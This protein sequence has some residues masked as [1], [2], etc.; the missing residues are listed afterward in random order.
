MLS[1]NLYLNIVLRVTAIILLALLLGYLVFM[2]KSVKL[3]LIC[4]A[5]IIA[6]TTELISFLNGVNSK[7]RF[8]FDSVRNDDS[9]INFNPGTTD[10]TLIEL[11]KSMMEVNKQISRLKLDNLRQEQYFRALI[12]HLAIGIITYDEKGMILH[13]NKA[14][15]KLLSMEVLTHIRQIGRKDQKLASAIDEIKPGENKLVSILNER[16]ETGLSLKATSV[17]IQSA[18]HIILS[19][20]DIG[21]ELEEKEIE[22]WLKLIRVLTHEIMNSITPITSLS[23]SLSKI[24]ITGNGRIGADQLTESKIET[25]IQGLNVIREQ[26]KGLLSF[27]ESYREMTRLPLP[28]KQLFS[29]S[30]LLDRVNMLYGSL[31][32]NDRARLFIELKNSKA[33]LYA[34]KNLISQ[35]LLNLLKNALE[36]IGDGIGGK[37]TINFV[38]GPDH[39]HE[40]SVSDNGPGIP[41]ENLDKVFVPFFT[42]RTRGTGIGLSISRQIM[43]S[44]GGILKV[45][46]V[47]GKETVFSLNF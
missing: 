18:R 16:G 1:R 47:P 22:S 26:G 8:F 7:I 42:T 11:Y 4:L 25:T 23:E 17:N 9:G 14:A 28:E 37:I 31:E 2:L 24:Y 6:V 38:E 36:S 29:V 13:A 46:S 39:H 5:V 33:E 43:K 41:E 35:V 15:L 3:S 40:I 19:I 30:D 20:Q 10:K 12:D 45:R 44:H 32:N 34:D 27:V 21:N